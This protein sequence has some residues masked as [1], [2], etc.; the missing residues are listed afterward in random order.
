MSNYFLTAIG[1]L[2][3]T[4]LI[5]FDEEL[6]RGFYASHVVMIIFVVLGSI[7]ALAIKP[8]SFLPIFLIGIYFCLLFL[9]SALIHGLGERFYRESVKAILLISSVWLIRLLTNTRD[10]INFTSLTPIIL[11]LYVFYKVDQLGIAGT[12]TYGGRLEIPSLGG[13]SNT[14]A[15]ILA[16]N[17]LAIQFFPF[18]S[19]GIWRIIRVPVWLGLFIALIFTFSRGG[20]FAYTI[21]TIIGIGPRRLFRIFIFSLAVIG[22]MYG[23]LIIL[24]EISPSVIGKFGIFARYNII[25]A[26]S[27]SGRFIIW[28]TLLNNWINTPTAWVTG[29]G[30]GSIYL[31]DFNKLVLSAH[32]VWLASLYYFGI[33]GFILLGIYMYILFVRSKHSVLFRKI[34]LAILSAIIFNFTIDTVTFASQATMWIILYL[35][36]ISSD[37]LPSKYYK[38]HWGNSEYRQ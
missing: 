33:L 16:L 35:G 31:I 24:K 28:A 30:P 27:E 8:N 2:L 6:L 14:M 38:P 17:L 20:F 25:A 21:G 18:F 36:I 7:I 29:F 19:R 3:F 26:G 10:L 5:F 34:K 9:T 1:T 4:F 23:A 22:L 12:F 37:E 15:I 32:S 13:S 11:L